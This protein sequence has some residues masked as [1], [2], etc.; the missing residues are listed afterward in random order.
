MKVSI[1]LVVIISLSVNGIMAQKTAK[2][3]NSKS[4][5]MDFSK[6]TNKEVKQALEALE[7]NNKEAWFALFTDDAK[8]T[9]DGRAMDFKSFFN[10]A[11][12][13]KE[14]FLA[15][16]KVENDSKDITGNFYAGQWGTFKVFFRFRQNADGKFHQLDIGQAK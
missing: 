15:I 13:K 7:E 1:I 11:F 4:I 16:E 14:K 3:S 10:N 5:K 6:I 2:Q 12:S 9:D 8:F